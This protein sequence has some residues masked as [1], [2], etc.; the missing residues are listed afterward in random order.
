MNMKMY[1]E[2]LTE[3][4]K[5][6]KKI[7]LQGKL[8]GNL[9]W[10]YISKLDGIADCMTADREITTGELEHLLNVKGRQTDYLIEL[11]TID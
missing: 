8:T 10:H 9:K 2:L 11:E 1:E 3:N 5:W 4:V 6:V 7:E